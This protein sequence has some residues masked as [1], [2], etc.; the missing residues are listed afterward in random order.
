[1]F[2][3]SS[4]S[5]SDLTLVL[6]FRSKFTKTSFAR[7]D[8]F[9]MILLLTSSVLLVFALEEA[10]TRYS[11]DSPVVIS[12]LV[13]AGVSGVTLFVWEVFVDE[14]TSSQEPVFPPS[15]LKNRLLSSMLA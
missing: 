2:L 1:M 6:R 9:G 8:I 7:I 14:A 11:W 4:S 15:L 3:P 10:G 13:L 5:S 12:T